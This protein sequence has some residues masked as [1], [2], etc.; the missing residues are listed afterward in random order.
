MP[1]NPVAMQG[2]QSSGSSALPI[3]LSWHWDN[4]MHLQGSK[5][6]QDT[7][8]TRQAYETWREE[9]RSGSYSKIAKEAQGDARG[10]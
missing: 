1:G 3:I 8:E 9:L 7:A 2:V 6:V 4:V 10:A 5:G